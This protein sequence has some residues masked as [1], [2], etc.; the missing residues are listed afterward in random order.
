MFEDEPPPAPRAAM[1]LTMAAT[2]RRMA[3]LQ[4]LAQQIAAAFDEGC[5]MSCVALADA[6]AAIG[7][8]SGALV[9]VLDPLDDTRG[10]T[11]ALDQ[12]DRT[13]KPHLVVTERRSAQGMGLGAMAIEAG[14]VAIAA[15]LRG[16]L[17]R[18]PEL[19]RLRTQASGAEHMVGGLRGDLARRQDELQ[20]AAQVQREFLPKSLPDL[21]RAQVAAMWRP[22]SWVSGDIYDARRLDEHH[23]GIFIA[24]AV[25]HG[26]P[27]ALMTMVIARSLPTKQIMGSTYRIVP[28]AEALATVNRSPRP[29]TRCSIF[30][31]FVC[32]WRAQAIRHRWCCAATITWSSSAARAAR[33]VCSRTSTGRRRKW[34]CTRAIACCCTPTASRRLSR[35]I[36]PRA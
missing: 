23:L 16:M 9:M 17:S 31:R 7:D 5:T 34:T 11:A 32:A 19:D 12:A 24:D 33:W 25:G 36:R 15:A 29:C 20:L 13:G 8:A 21:P 35:R 3:S 26:V 1:H 30:A 14:P 4:S 27:A 6:A 2:P 18:Q 22:A 28:P 10:L